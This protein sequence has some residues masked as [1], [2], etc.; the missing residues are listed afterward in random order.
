MRKH[1]D[2]LLP[3]FLQIFVTVYQGVKMCENYVTKLSL[4]TGNETCSLTKAKQM[5]CKK[6]IY[7]FRNYLQMNDTTFDHLLNMVEPYVTKENIVMRPSVSPE[8]HLSATFRLLAT[9]RSY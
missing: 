3:L 8:E 7:Y 5:H 4:P 9:G 6:N 1:H 2:Y